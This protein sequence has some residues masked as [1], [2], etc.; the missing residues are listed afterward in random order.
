MHR[1]ARSSSSC[2]PNVIQDPK[3]S[4]L[5]LSPDRP[6]RLYSMSMGPFL[7]RVGHLRMT[8]VGFRTRSGW[9]VAV[10]VDGSGDE[11]EAVGRWRVPLLDDSLPRQVGHAP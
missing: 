2:G 11:P 5:T 3:E 10:A 8:G 1:M 4:T 7:P 6:S 9:A